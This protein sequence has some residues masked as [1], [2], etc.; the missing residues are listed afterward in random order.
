MMFLAA[1][2]SLE[3]V[4]DK[5]RDFPSPPHGRFGFVL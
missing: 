1:R 4:E 3:E 2:L 5:T